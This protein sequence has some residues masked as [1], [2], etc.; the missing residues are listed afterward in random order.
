MEHELSYITARLHCTEQEKRDCLPLAF[1][2]LDMSSHARENGIATLEQAFTSSEAYASSPLLRKA[3]ELLSESYAP[4]T[5][6]EILR[7]YILEGDYYASA[8]LKSI[9]IMVGVLSIQQG[10]CPSTLARRLAAYF[11]IEFDTVFQDALDNYE[12]AKKEK[13]QPVREYIRSIKDQKPF[14]EKTILL[15]KLISEDSCV[16]KRLLG[17]DIL[18]LLQHLGVH[19]FVTALLGASGR[20]KRYFLMW[21]PRRTQYTIVS[22][23]SS[24]KAFTEEGIVSA[25]KK[26]LELMHTLY[27][28]GEIFYNVDAL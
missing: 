26:M 3:I 10:E 15:E 17:N 1:T 18:T 6:R 13:A 7:G 9:L 24:Q 21:L 19:H 28:E 12:A 20:I 22:E 4:D 16:E 8:F 11:G 27:G 2:L 14:S 25:Q 23:M 5:I